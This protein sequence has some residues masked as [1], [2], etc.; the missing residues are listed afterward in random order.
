M[1]VRYL[2]NVNNFIMGLFPVIFRI[3]SYSLLQN[4][5]YI[6]EYQKEKEVI[7][8]EEL[9]KKIHIKDVIK[10]KE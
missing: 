8:S 2:G 1:H 5:V 6:F 3:L 9:K 10:E 4:D 7:K